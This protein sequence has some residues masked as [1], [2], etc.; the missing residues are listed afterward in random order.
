MPQ[1][2]EAMRNIRR[3]QTLLPAVLLTTQIPGLGGRSSCDQ[4]SNDLALQHEERQASF[5]SSVALPR[6]CFF[7]FAVVGWLYSLCKSRLFFICAIL[8]DARASGLTIG[9]AVTDYSERVL[10]E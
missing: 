10:D 9:A 6:C 2:S 5:F 4:V 8:Q 1:A 7:A 3:R